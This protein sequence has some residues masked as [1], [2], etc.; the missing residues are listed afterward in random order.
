MLPEDELQALAD[1][2]K[3]NGLLH[4]IIIDAEGVLIDGR[5]RLTAC[6][7]AQVEPRW[8]MLGERKAKAVI[9][10]ANLARRDLNKGQKAILLAMIYPEP[11]RGRGKKD[12]AGKVLETRAFSR[13]RLEQAR[14][15]LRLNRAYA[16]D[17]VHRAR[18]FDETLEEVKK[19]EREASSTDALIAKLRK[20]A[21]DL[22]ELVDEE[23]LTLPDAR[24]AAADRIQKLKGMTDAAKKYVGLIAAVPGYLTSIKIGI[25]ALADMPPPDDAPDDDAPEPETPAEVILGELDFDALHQALDELEALLPP[26]EELEAIK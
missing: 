16:E 14:T 2:I 20:Q 26:V 13:Q 3:A 18:K 11:E 21:P 1:D 23:R 4:P 7:I 10:S 6:E 17:I 12:E 25:R 8:E 9:A 19:K 24:A 15:I 22:A 5:N